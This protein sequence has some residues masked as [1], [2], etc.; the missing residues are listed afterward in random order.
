MLYDVGAGTGAVSVDAALKMPLG[1]VYAIEKNTAAV[2]LCRQNALKFAADNIEIIEG[3]APEA[4]SELPA[5]THA[6]IG[7]SGGN[8][9]DIISCV[10]SKNKAAKIV[11]NIISLTTLSE[12]VNMLDELG[13]EGDI[14][15]LSCAKQQL[16]GKH[17][18]MLA[19]NPVYVVAVNGGR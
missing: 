17:R 18:L 1:K 11:I 15:S 7:G 10:L 3:E 12:V 5:P 8:M 14:V 4:L 2:E 13:L 19:Q 16:A 6:F 9:R